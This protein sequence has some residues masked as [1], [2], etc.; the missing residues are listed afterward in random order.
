MQADAYHKLE[1][2]TTM[3]FLERHLPKRGLVLDAGGG[4]GRYS[5][6]LAK[7]KHDMVLLDLTP[8]NLEFAIQKIGRE[9]LGNRFKAVVEGNI[10]DL[11]MF[12]DKTFDAVLCLGGALSHVG[13]EKDRKKAVSELFRVAKR[14]APV[15]VSVMGIYGTMLDGPRKWP[16]D[17]RKTRYFLDVVRTRDDYSWIGKYYSHFFTRAEFE[18]LMRAPKT[19]LLEIVGLE[20]F[21]SGNPEA[22]NALAKDKKA[23]RNWVNAHLSLCTNPSVADLSAHMMAIS[24][25]R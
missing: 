2:D 6:A 22:A 1:F 17:I 23:W 14:N 12:E 3:H 13:S 16:K 9:K 25:K 18:R 19:R 15:F 24:R 20:G 10:V 8:E 11:S 5:I 4:P 7:K 21:S